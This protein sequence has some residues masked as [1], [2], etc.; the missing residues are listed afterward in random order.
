M[1]LTET[2][3]HSVITDCLTIPCQPIKGC[4]IVLDTNVILDLIFWHD[5]KAEPIRQA[6]DT[7]LITVLRDEETIIELAEVLARPHFLGDETK[8]IEAVKAWCQQTAHIDNA[9]IATAQ[10]HISVRCRDPLDQ[11]FLVL[12]LAGK[13]PLLVTQ[14]KLVLKAGKK[15]ARYGTITIKPDGVPAAFVALKLQRP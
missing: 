5:P 2:L 9:A 4:P 8:A 1:S 10:D 15:M 7:G 11:K 14:D 6:L 12:T 13:A 3:R